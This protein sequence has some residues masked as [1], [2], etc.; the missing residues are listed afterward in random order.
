MLPAVMLGFWSLVASVLYLVPVV[1][2]LAVRSRPSRSILGYALD[3]PLAVGADLLLVLLLGKVL[4]V[5]HAALVARAV[6]LSVLGEW[7]YQHRAALRDGAWQK[8][9]WSHR[10]TLVTVIGAGIV[11]LLLS[12]GISVPYGV[13]DREWHVP[14]TAAL[15]DQKI[16]ATNIYEPNGFIIYHYAG[17]LLGAILQGLSFSHIHASRGLSYAH[18]LMYFLCGIT[19]ALVARHK[20]RSRLAMIGAALLY[21]L[22]GPVTLKKIANPFEGHTD[23]A[24]INLSFRPHVVVAMVLVLGF[25]LAVLLRTE[26]PDRPDTET[27][28][29]LVVCTAALSLADEM[30]TAVLGLSLGVSWFVWPSLVARTR[31]RGAVVLS[32]LLVAIFAAN[33]FFYGTLRPGGPVNK[34]AIVPAAMRGFFGIT[35]APL[36]TEAG[37][38]Y[39]GLDAATSLAALA[40]AGLA[41]AR[42]TARKDRGAAFF[43]L[44]VLGLS[45]YAFLC[46]EFNRRWFEAHRSMTLARCVS[47]LVVGAW[48][49][50]GV[51]STVATWVCGA[52]AFSSL[53]FLIHQAPSRCADYRGSGIYHPATYSID[54]KA[55]TGA[56]SRRPQ[57]VVGD[58]IVAW[59]KYAGCH[60]VLSPPA[61]G[62][63]EFETKLLQ[64]G[65]PRLGRD[66]LLHMHTEMA[67]P[68]EVVDLICAVEKPGLCHRAEQTADCGRLGTDLVRCRLTG[69]DRARLLAE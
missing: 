41:F 1:A 69:E 22:A 19:L 7:V 65:P 34:V 35:P 17:D 21:V 12:R 8:K 10:W 4:I 39:F 40:V 18:D 63:T 54:C 2:V 56:G 49:G 31:L 51:V 64:G 16:P 60:A 67:R 53:G 66:G 13:W 5:R 52:A 28:L 25:V 47:T 11:C 45:V 58:S 37:L 6:W 62:G 43:V 14:G 50:E 24:S 44:A 59:Y 33:H 68:D 57:L 48:F 23:M 38:T 29:P 61:W 15:A 3:V 55:A 27:I 36:W 32:A 9:L 42:P 30:A 46:V 26:E 20:G